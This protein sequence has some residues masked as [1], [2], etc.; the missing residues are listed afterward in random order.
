MHNILHALSAQ[1]TMK[2]PVFWRIVRG[3]HQAEEEEVPV[4]EGQD[5]IATAGEFASA[6]QMPD[7]RALAAT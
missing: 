5:E 4:N 2:R 7:A 3:I 6:R 1:P